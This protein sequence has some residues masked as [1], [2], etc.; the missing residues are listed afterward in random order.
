MRDDEPPQ[1]FDKEQ[2]KKRRRRKKSTRSQTEEGKWKE[3]YRTLFPND[4]EA[5]I[6]SPC[7]RPHSYWKSSQKS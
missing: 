7:K 4:N 5:T 3:M 6:L 2:E 1:G